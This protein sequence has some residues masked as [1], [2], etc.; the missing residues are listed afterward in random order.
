MAQRRG[1]TLWD[2]T[3]LAALL[4]VQGQISADPAAAMVLAGLPGHLVDRL[5]DAGLGDRFT[6]ADSADEA[7]GMVAPPTV[8][9][10]PDGRS[11]SP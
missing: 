3:G 2:S 4:A 8:P 11:P 7:L 5:H 1:L 6:L 9:P 10:S